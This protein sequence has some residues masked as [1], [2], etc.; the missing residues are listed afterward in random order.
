M[1]ARDLVR[2]LIAGDLDAQVRVWMPDMNL[3]EDGSVPIRDM[4]VGMVVPAEQGVID[5]D[6][7]ERKP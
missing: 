6:M 2:E 5:L 1:K 4:T 7:I 3:G